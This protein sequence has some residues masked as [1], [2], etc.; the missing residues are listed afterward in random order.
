M[1]RTQVMSECF[2][3]TGAAMLPCSFQINHVIEIGFCV[4]CGIKW[5][6]IIFTDDK[7]NHSGIR[8]Q[9]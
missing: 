4:F 9:T 5:F 3:L 7:L 1:C 8:D 6:K 2:S